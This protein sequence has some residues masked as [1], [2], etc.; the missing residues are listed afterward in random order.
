M[1]GELNTVQMHPKLYVLSSYVKA[2]PVAQLVESWTP[3][4]EN[5]GLRRSGTL[6]ETPD[7]DGPVGGNSSS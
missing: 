5:P 3:G 1:Q 2:C 4:S 6:Y 7:W